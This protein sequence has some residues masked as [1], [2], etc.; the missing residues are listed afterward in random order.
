MYEREFN[1]VMSD[2]VK[3]KFCEV[4]G[5]SQVQIKRI[6]RSYGKGADLLIIENVPVG[7]CA[8]CGESYLSA[9]TLHEIARI[10]LHGKSFAKKQNSAAA[11]FV[12]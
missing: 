3:N 4:C 10:K 8:C 11:E 7:F 12:G 1:R 2:K 9:E 5:K 6:T